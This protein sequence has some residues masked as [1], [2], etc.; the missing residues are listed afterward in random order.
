MD[1]DGCRE[2]YSDNVKRSNRD[3]N[4]PQSIGD[5]PYDLDN[6]VCGIKLMAKAQWARAQKVSK[7]AA[8]LV[9]ERAGYQPIKAVGCQDG[10]GAGGG[11]YTF[12]DKVLSASDCAKKAASADRCV[13]AESVVIQD[14]SGPKSCTCNQGT[15]LGR[16]KMQKKM[17]KL[18]HKITETD[19][20]Y[21]SPKETYVPIKAEFCTGGDGNGYKEVNVG[22]VRNAKECVA[23]S[24]LADVCNGANG[25]TIQQGKGDTATRLCYCE[26]GMSGGS[27]GGWENCRLN[28]Q[29]T[30]ADKVWA[31]G[32]MR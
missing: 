21:N 26:F 15:D 30:G 16:P 17:C 2:S 18:N 32:K 5:L 7:T 12:P 29:I 8:Q 9:Q 22:K 19:I 31:D 23:K 3:N 24:T 14:I 11:G 4:F 6:D 28:R 20:N 10:D 27:G 1:E 13:G 25:I